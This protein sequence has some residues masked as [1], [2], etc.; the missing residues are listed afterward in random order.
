[1]RETLKFHSGDSSPREG[2]ASQLIYRVLRKNKKHKQFHSIALLGQK[3]NA[4]SKKW[5]KWTNENLS[6]TLHPTTSSATPQ[7]RTLFVC[8]FGEVKSPQARGARWINRGRSRST[9]SPAIL[10]NYRSAETEL[11]S[12]IAF[13]KWRLKVQKVQT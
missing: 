7:H 12:S 3:Q 4:K 6:T 8:V 9:L 11:H 1:M 5:P 2:R 10:N 13:P